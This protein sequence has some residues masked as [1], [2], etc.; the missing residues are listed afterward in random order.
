MPPFQRKKIFNFSLIGLIGLILSC[1]TWTLVYATAFT[2]GYQTTT[3]LSVGTVVS[4][5]KNSNSQIEPTNPDNDSRLI[6]VI[7]PA[8][9]SIIDIQPLGSNIRVATSGD[10]TLLVTD[11]AGDIKKGDNLIISSLAG[12]AMR[13]QAN[14]IASKYLAVAKESFSSSSVGAQKVSVSLSNGG[15]QTV[16]VGKIVA[17]ILISDRKSPIVT[18]KTNNFFTNLGKRIA[19]KDVSL[20]RMIVS[21][22]VLLTAFSITG[23]LLNASVKG[24]FNSLGRNPLAKISIMTSLMRIIALSIFIFGIGISLAY[25]I[26]VF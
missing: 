26:I 22:I 1:L 17:T 11:S 18:P 7:A 9:S 3:D 8:N 6:G 13:D 23:W 15:K 24:S 10:A 2:E 19:G 4:I 25:L 20:L 21:I 14:A 16:S 12:I 5:A